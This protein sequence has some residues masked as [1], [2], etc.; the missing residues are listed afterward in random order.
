MLK[1]KNKFLFFCSTIVGSIAFYPALITIAFLILAIIMLQTE[2]YG[3]SKYMSENVPYI[4]VNNKDTARTILS[5]IISGIM[6]I[7]VFS[8]SMVMLLLNQASS[9]FSPRVLPSLIAN[10]KHQFVL[11]VFIGTIVYCLLV[12]INILPD[13]RTYNVP[14]FATF[15]GVLLGLFCLALFVYFLHSISKSIQ[16]G[17]ILEK[18][19]KDTLQGIESEIAK[20]SQRRKVLPNHNNWQTV[21]STETGYLQR[22][23]EQ[24]LLDFAKKH[25]TSILITVPEGKFVIKDEPICKV[26]NGL[27]EE[28][29]K[30]IASCLLFS[31]EERIEQNFVMGFKQI[32]EI[33]VKA[34]SPG[35][36]DPGTA[37]IGIDYLSEL[38]RRRMELPDNVELDIKMKEGDSEQRQEKVFLKNTPFEDIFYLNIASIRQY[39]RQDV[40]VLLRLLDFY[41]SLLNVKNIPDDK[42]KFLKKQLHFLLSDIKEHI[43]NQGDRSHLM[44]IGENL[45]K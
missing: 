28:T 37:L 22:I 42:E 20:K 27:D 30:E 11:G 17:Y 9:N 26:A 41:K 33:V 13:H 1:I 31:T 4:I 10:K 38:F 29:R 15:F 12:T 24:H 32:T 21:R 5:T 36:N 6:S 35:I 2:N 8:F 16:I 23:I 43:T 44:E 14:G 45:L 7:M 25:E 18:L 40:V 3:V 19:Y 34:M 39:I